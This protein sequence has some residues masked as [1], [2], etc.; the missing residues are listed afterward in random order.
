MKKIKKSS[1]EESE[2][3]K[4]LLDKIS[5]H[6]DASPFKFATNEEDRL[7]HSLISIE[8]ENIDI[9]T[10]PLYEEI[11]NIFHEQLNVATEQSSSWMDYYSFISKLN[12]ILTSQEDSRSMINEEIFAQLKDIPSQR[13]MT[14]YNEF[15]QS[16]KS[17]PDN[18]W[19][20]TLMG[21]IV[22]ILNHQFKFRKIIIFGTQEAV[23]YVDSYAVK[24]TSLKNKARLI[25]DAF[26]Q[27]HIFEDQ[28]FV[29]FKC[30]GQRAETWTQRPF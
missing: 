13:I 5:Q 19:E 7:F 24:G 30:G 17:L 20:S 10:N 23:Q 15:L 25:P 2:E 21:M 22:N 6:D 8:N 12:K 1:L 18:V 11:S 9:T 26:A 29:F 14:V 3:V 16:Q 27:I 4:K 28:P